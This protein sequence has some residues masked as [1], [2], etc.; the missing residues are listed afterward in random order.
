[1][2]TENPMISDPAL[3]ENTL[4][5]YKQGVD[6]VKE[7]FASGDEEG[8]RAQQKEL[9]GFVQ[10][11]QPVLSAAANSRQFGDA[12]T[13][14]ARRALSG[15]HRIGIDPNLQSKYTNPNIL[16]F[17]ADQMQ[18]GDAT[19]RMYQTTELNPGADIVADVAMGRSLRK[20]TEAAQTLLPRGANGKATPSFHLIDAEETN[21]LFESTFAD[22][23]GWIAGF[24]V[25]KSQ[26][27]GAFSMQTPEDQ[28]A[29]D[30]FMSSRRE[31]ADA[32]YD[33]AD[34]VASSKMS[35]SVLARARENVDKMFEKTPGERAPRDKATMTAKASAYRD[36]ISSFAEVFQGG[37]LDENVID[38]LFDKAAGEVPAVQFG[39]KPALVNSAV[40]R[41]KESITALNSVT[42]PDIKAATQI[43]SMIQKLHKE[44]A[45]G[46]DPRVQQLGA[47][48]QRATT[49]KW[50]PE[51]TRMVTGWLAQSKYDNATAV[52][53]SIKAMDEFSS[54]LDPETMDGTSYS[55]ARSAFVGSALMRG[56]TGDPA[57]TKLANGLRT[58]KTLSDAMAK[59]AQADPSMRT[60]ILA[61]YA[62]KFIAAVSTAAET[63]LDSAQAI[64]AAQALSSKM[65][66]D[67]VVSNA[68]EATKLLRDTY[69]SVM[70]NMNASQ[71]PGPLE[72]R[73]N[74]ALSAALDLNKDVAS[75]ISVAADSHKFNLA[76]TGAM[77][78]VSRQKD[79]YTKAGQLPNTEVAST[80]EA[81]ATTPGNS[82][83][84]EQEAAEYYAA[85]QTSQKS[86]SIGNPK[87]LE[88]G[89]TPT[90]AV[91]VKPAYQV[92]RDSN[93]T[94]DQMRKDIIASGAGNSTDAYAIRR[95]FD[96]K[97]DTL[98]RRDG[99]PKFQGTLVKG[100]KESTF[101]VDTIKG[102]L[103]PASDAAAGADYRNEVVKIAQLANMSGAANLD[104]K[105]SIEAR[106]AEFDRFLNQDVGINGA[107]VLWDSAGKARRKK[108][109]EAYKSALGHNPAK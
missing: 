9:D 13:D 92:L 95:I 18:M 93:L 49:P 11:Y 30:A 100:S 56:N 75:D 27:P 90:G 14:V 35:P 60:A 31:I 19:R 67:G 38:Q 22:S 79:D 20:A 88:D 62:S 55:Q 77:S 17:R 73:M 12:I 61:P 10:S 57:S 108:L 41:F 36:V 104:P 68:D 24:D 50:S 78:Q 98:F 89:Q 76:M 53:M 5:F 59:G 2:S 82:P 21:S 103:G 72:A 39:D 23:A 47:A 1:M 43:A 33:V 99:R 15:E 44:G 16:Q 46:D 69:T 42:G 91:V 45:T 3:I 29:S 58:A 81:M 8:A 70:S 48:Y 26:A 107:S 4:S 40:R 105:R 6:R 101:L 80:F 109:V 74:T 54:L 96:N 94:F 63:G 7:K 71:T 64:T 83:V 102:A 87:K 86:T 34:I 28:S 66:S 106:V 51:D 65:L 85:Y 37:T 52:N 25:N 32:L 84:N 97:Y